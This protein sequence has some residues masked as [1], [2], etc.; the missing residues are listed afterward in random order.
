MTCQVTMFEQTKNHNGQRQIV[1]F[2][3]AMQPNITNIKP[4]WFV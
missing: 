3:K 1:T 2:H 4:Q